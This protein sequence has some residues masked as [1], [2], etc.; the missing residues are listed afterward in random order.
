VSKQ[1]ASDLLYGRRGSMIAH[2]RA[3]TCCHCRKRL[4]EG[5]FLFCDDFCRDRAKTNVRKAYLGSKRADELDDVWPEPPASAGCPSCDAAQLERSRMDG[6]RTHLAEAR[7]ILE[8]A[9]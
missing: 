8:G 1:S 5:R 6:G 2:E 3:L 7:T 4:P 9:P